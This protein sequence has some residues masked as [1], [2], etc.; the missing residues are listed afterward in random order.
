MVI[1]RARKYPS[2][3]FTIRLDFDG[4]LP[5]G[6]TIASASLA[7]FKRSD[8]TSDDSI[9]ED[10]TPTPTS[11]TVPVRLQAGSAGE[12]YKILIAVTLSNSDVLYEIMIV[13]VMST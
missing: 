7:A 9:L 13:S 1:H 3:I 6:Q 2:E 11:T 5:S 8:G 4:E 12:S 10:T